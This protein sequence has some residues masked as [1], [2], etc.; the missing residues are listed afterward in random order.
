MTAR[1][2]A[3]VHVAISGR[4]EQQRAHS[5]VYGP[6]PG[7]FVGGQSPGIYLY[8]HMYTPVNR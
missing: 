4:R 6:L 7:G 2:G 3:S 8:V 1:R 5:P